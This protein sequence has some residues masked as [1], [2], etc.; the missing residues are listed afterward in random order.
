MMTV[1][2]NLKGGS[3]KSTVTFN[4]ALW[5]LRAGKTVIAYDLDLQCTLSDVAQVRHEEGYEPPL[6]VYTRYN[7]LTE[8]ENE[9][10]MDIGA[11]NMAGMKRAIAA[12]DRIVVP[13]APSQADIW[14]TQRFLYII[15]SESRD[16]PPEVIVFINRADTH[17]N[18]R[19]SDETEE[20]L[21]ALPGIKVLPI[22]LCQRTMYR[23]SFSEG[24]AVFELEPTGKAAQEFQVLAKSLYPQVK[25]G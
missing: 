2:G 15:A 25:Y 11:A 1:V 21:R 9:I 18:V 19:E 4:L 6:K 7:K 5:L 3:G 24:L 8:A 12:A 22:R 10:L 23:R 13:V 17:A 20:A 14:S 16:K